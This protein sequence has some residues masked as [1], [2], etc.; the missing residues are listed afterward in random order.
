MSPSSPTQADISPSATSSTTHLKATYSN[1]NSTENP[2]SSSLSSTTPFTISTQLSL[3]STESAA[4]KTTYL[5][6]LREAVLSL[7]E[8]VNSELTRR[9][10]EEV[11]EVAALSTDPS[12]S[13]G[14]RVDGAGAAQIDEAAEEENYGEEVVQDEE[15]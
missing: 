10:E 2:S 8:R 15:D 12:T 6:T 13:N 9:M 5:N 4:H 3:P 11:R 14:K 7:Q 1:S